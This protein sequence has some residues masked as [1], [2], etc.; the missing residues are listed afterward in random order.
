LKKTGAKIN[1]KTGKQKQKN[2]ISVIISLRPF[3][4]VKELFLMDYNDELP[5]KLVD[6]FLEKPAF[7]THTS[8][9]G[10][11]KVYAN[12]FRT[13]ASFAL[14]M[15]ISVEQVN[16]WRQAY[17]IFADACYH[18][19]TIQLENVMQLLIQKLIT[20]DVA[21]FLYGSIKESSEYVLGRNL[22]SLFEKIDQI[23]LLEG[24]GTAPNG[25][26]KK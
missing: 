5:R 22:N 13:F 18:C 12:E 16:A 14:K 7:N 8:K 17:P 6:F 23:P 25:K 10:A 21:K 4:K 15:R 20:L 9:R 2:G 3:R 24:A 19:V 1:K 11:V 26:S